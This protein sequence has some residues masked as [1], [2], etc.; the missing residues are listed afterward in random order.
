MN[1]STNEVL[2]PARRA[3][4]SRA[5]GRRTMPRSRKELIKRIHDAVLAAE[6]HH[7][8]YWIYKNR[9]DRAKYIDTMNK[10]VGFF[11]SSIQAHFIALL[12]I[13]YAVY[14]RRRD[15]IN[16]VRL[17]EGCPA[18]LRAGLSTDFARAKAI[19]QKIAIL[20]NNHF[21]HVSEHLEIDAVFD[22]ARATYSEIKELIDI[23]KKLLNAV[24]YAEDRSSFADSLDSAK[25][26]Y[27]LLEKL[28][29]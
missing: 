20:R 18:D 28:R 22:R 13:L 11:A 21:A 26:T 8:I 15:T 6:L 4:Y 16:L 9:D 19:W 3:R 1:Q 27:R 7:K 25:D 17:Y 14:E 5:M 29:S 12:V 2:R 10:Y 23:Y 24:S